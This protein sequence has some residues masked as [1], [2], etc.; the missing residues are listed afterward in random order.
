MRR[1]P[2]LRTAISERSNPGS[3]APG[4]PLRRSSNRRWVRRQPAATPANGTVT[5]TRRPKRR[6]V[7]C[8]GIWNCFGGGVYGVP[9]PAATGIASSMNCREFK[10]KHVGFIDD[11]LSAADMAD[12]RQHLRACVPCGTLDVRIRRSL[13]VVRNLPQI[14]PSADFYL[15]LSERLR[16]APSPSAS[17]RS[18]IATTIVVVFAAL[19]AAV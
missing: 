10:A 16:T 9:N 7:L 2:R 15:R 19:A 17:R 1:S 5:L 6:L 8:L 14:E 18:S 11:V 4:R 13:L 3:T 12:M